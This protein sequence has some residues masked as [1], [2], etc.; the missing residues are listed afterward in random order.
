[1]RVVLASGGER[2]ESVGR[3]Q[4]TGVKISLS[5]LFQTLT[6][7]L[8]YF[9]MSDKLIFNFRSCPGWQDRLSL[10]NCSTPAHALS[11]ITKTPLS[12]LCPR[13]QTLRKLCWCSLYSLQLFN[14]FAGIEL[15]LTSPP[16]APSSS[17]PPLN[18]SPWLQW[19]RVDLYSVSFF[20]SLILTLC[21]ETVY[22]AYGAIT[23]RPVN[24]LLTN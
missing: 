24:K 17:S 23:G 22:R 12:L 8:Y 1:M 15:E 21:V 16:C 7:L 11:A 10:S 19:V 20:L 3:T 4:L 2:E 14:M 13:V 9:L 18:S 5:R 6:H